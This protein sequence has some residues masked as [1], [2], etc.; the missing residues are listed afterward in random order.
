MAA[1]DDFLTTAGDV[2][3]QIW[4]AATTAVDPPDRTVVIAAGLVAL[5]VVAV[6]PVWRV[7]RHVITIAH[8]GAHAVVAMLTGRRLDGIRL[9]SDT[10]GLTVTAGRPRGLGMILTAF[11]GYVGPGLVGLG[12][13]WLLRAGYA[14]G[15]LWLL[16]VLLALLLLKIRNWFGLWS[17][18]VSG[19]LLVGVSWWLDPTVQSAVAYAVTWFLLL[20]AV[21]PVA[22][23]QSQRARGRARTSDADQLGRL[24]G[25]PGIVWVLIFFLVTVGA[26]VLGGSWIVGPVTTA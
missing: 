3:A 25:V 19:A 26:L 20:G 8:E 23:L 22:E 2:L 10:S 18:L 14:V 4:T 12:A 7:A 24:T 15:L 21:R 16:V 11:A 1:V 17:V 13:A 6:S 5:A 9:H